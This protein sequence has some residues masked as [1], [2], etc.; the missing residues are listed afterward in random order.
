MG[1]T[2][3]YFRSSLWS[4]LKAA[5]FLLSDHACWWV[6][7]GSKVDFWHDQWLR[8]ALVDTLHVPSQAA[9]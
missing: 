1:D 8:G 7:S 3:Q 2:L 9:A 5:M 4:G 6:G